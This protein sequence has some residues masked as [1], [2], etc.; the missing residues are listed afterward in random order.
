[1]NPGDAVRYYTE[2]IKSFQRGE[3]HVLFTR[4]T[5]AY[6]ATVEHHNRFTFGDE[7]FHNVDVVKLWMNVDLYG[8]NLAALNFQKKRLVVFDKS[9]KI[10]KL[11]SSAWFKSGESGLMV[12]HLS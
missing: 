8:G 7:E 1:M 11:G 5:F 3:K 10:L 6:V 9:G 4:A 12:S 2:L